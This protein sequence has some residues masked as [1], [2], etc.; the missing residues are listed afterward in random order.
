MDPLITISDRLKRNEQ[1]DKEIATISLRINDLNIQHHALQDT[2][3]QNNRALDKALSP[4][5]KY[6]TIKIGDSYLNVINR[7]IFFNIQPTTVPDIGD[8]PC[9][10]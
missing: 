10:L 1:L 9:P 7:G 2:K 5:Y 3:D 6:T 8:I 4:Y